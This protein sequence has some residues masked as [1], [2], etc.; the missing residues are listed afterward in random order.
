MVTRHDNDRRPLASDVLLE[1]V[2]SPDEASDSPE[3]EAD[4][5]WVDILKYLPTTEIPLVLEKHIRGQLDS[6]TPEPP[7]PATRGDDARPSLSPGDSEGAPT[8]SAG[9]AV[10]DGIIKPHRQAPLV[11]PPLVSPEVSTSAP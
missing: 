8:G 4:M 9:S 5:S 7:A 3:E 6:D 10:E 11:T 1:L 2:D